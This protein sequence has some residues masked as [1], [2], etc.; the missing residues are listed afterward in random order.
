MIALKGQT[1]SRMIH[2]AKFVK[3]AHYNF[4]IT[5]VNL[6]INLARRRIKGPTS[7]I[8]AAGGY[9]G[10][11]NNAKT[12]DTPRTSK[13]PGGTWLPCTR[14]SE[15]PGTQQAKCALHPQSISD[16]LLM[17]EKNSGMGQSCLWLR[18]AILQD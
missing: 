8:G 14:H 7:E 3:K 6:L 17:P 1:L 4:I 16:G 10:E 18:T 2:F 15:S 13:S 12:S 11:E 5:S 9:H